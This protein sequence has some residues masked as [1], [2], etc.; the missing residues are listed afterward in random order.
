M[1]KDAWW[2]PSLL[3]FIGLAAFVVYSTW[4]A[5]QGEHYSFGNYLSPFYSP[6]LFGNSPHSL[7]GAKP[8]WIPSWLPFSPALL[9]LWAP[10]GFRMTCYYYRGAY[11]KAFWADPPACAVGEPRHN[12]R[13]ERKFPLILQNV[14]RYFLYI[15]LIFL[16]F[17][18]WDAINAYRF[19]D[20]FHVNLGSII[21]TANVFFLGGYTFSCH[22]LR[23]LIGGNCDELSK[24]PIQHKAYGCVSYLNKRHM[25][26]AWCSL[27][28]VGFSDIYVRMLSMGVWSDFR[29][30]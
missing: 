11:Y 21:L 10:A 26:W 22:S 30:F 24:L 13:G 18:A 5:F 27:F 17:L 6:E 23:H 15:A 2:L 19:A 1:R 16:I 7:F 9:I 8:A 28:V 3:T 14:H 29:I 4:A 25:L 12:Y 20:G